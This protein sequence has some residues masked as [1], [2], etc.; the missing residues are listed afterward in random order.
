MEKISIT[1][2]FA[3]Q[4]A[5]RKNLDI[6]GESLSFTIAEIELIRSRS[7][8]DPAFTASSSGGIS[9]TPGHNFLQSNTM[10]SSIG[11]SQYVFTGGTISTTTQTGFTNTETRGASST[12]WQSS[13]GLNLSQPLLRNAGSRITN[14]GITLAE[15]SRD[16]ARERF[17]S[18]NLDTVLGVISSYNRLYTLRQLLETRL[19]ALASAENLLREVDRRAQ[20]GPMQGM[21]RADAA[22]AVAQRRRDLVDAE[23]NLID[24]E[25]V[26][27]YLIGLEEKIRIVPI[28]PPSSEELRETEEQAIL[29][30]L[31][32]RPEIRELRL[33]LEAAELQE[34][35]AHQQTLPELLFTASGG[36]SGTGDT[37]GKSFQQIGEHST[38]FW[39]AGM[40]LN[41]PIGNTAWEN[42]YRRSRVRTEQVRNQVHSLSWKIRNDIEADMRALISARLQRQITAQ[43]QQIAVGRLEEYRKNNRLGSSP[44]QDVINAENDLISA[45]NGT[46]DAAETFAFA[47]AKLWRDM[48]VLLDR[49]GIRL[50]QQRPDK[51]LREIPG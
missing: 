2:D 15:I 18:I 9:Y 24:Q 28:D 51:V 41:V 34:R 39:T 40:L 7:I 29:T 32:L 6:R 35:V 25:A 47:V 49:Q 11:L 50:Q 16:D 44:L 27:R 3:I 30:A 1:R 43:A 20:P 5:I 46:F 14:L 48:G 23:R 45:R 21:E 22:Y 10:T 17:H 8:Y 31:E 42:D 36:F 37:F 19:N 33:S 38:R 12:S 26:L 13:V 4:M